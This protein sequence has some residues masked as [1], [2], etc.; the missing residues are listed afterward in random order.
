VLN[1]QL[2]EHVFEVVV[3]YDY[4]FVIG[5]S[6]G[7]ANPQQG[8]FLVRYSTDESPRK[9]FYMLGMEIQ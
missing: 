6:Y 4:E 1:W 2:F 3:D 7:N 9:V 8:S 5:Y